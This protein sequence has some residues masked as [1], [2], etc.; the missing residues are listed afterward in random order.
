[1]E[2]KITKINNLTIYPTGAI[3]WTAVHFKLDG[4]D[5]FLHASGEDYEDHMTLYRGRNKG[6]LERVSGCYGIDRDL[7]KFTKKPGCLKYVD[8]EHFIGELKKY[9]L[10]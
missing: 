1:M 3:G 9:K 5:H 6:H 4:V 10:L 8:I 7:I 2:I